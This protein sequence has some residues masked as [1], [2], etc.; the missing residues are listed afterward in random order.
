MRQTPRTLL[1]KLWD[2]HVVAQETDSPAVLYVDLHFINEV[3]SLLAFAGLRRR[4]F[5]V[6]RPDRTVAT[7]DH[8][9]S[10]DPLRLSAVGSAGADLVAHL[11]ENCRQ[12]TVT[13]YRPDSEHQGITHVIGP[14]LGLTQPGMTVASGDS[15]TCTHGAF[16]ALAI[17]TA[18]SGVEHLLATQCLLED[19][20][21]AFLVCVEGQ[22]RPGVSA[23]D[24]ILALIAQIGVD[25]GAGHALEFAGQAVRSMDMEGRLTLCNMAVEA[26]ARTGM[27]APD[28]VT[29]EYL[30]EREFAPRGPAWER[31]VRRWRELA[32]DE[33]ATYHRSVDIDS[34]SLEPMISYG[35]NPAMSIP[36]THVVPDPADLP[37]A[38]R[39][40]ALEA[41]LRYMNL[42]PGRPLLGHKVDV[43]FIG[44]C[45]NSRLSDLRQAAALLVGR[46]VA[47]GVRVLVVPG[48]QA[49]KRQAEAEGLARI[50]RQAGAEWRL[51]G[52]SMCIA[53]NGD[54]LEPGQY[55]VSTI[56]RSFEGRQGRGGRT[57]LASPLTAAAAAITGRVTD[58]RT[59]L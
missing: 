59:L 25:G 54:Q 40:T 47:Q 21:D 16:G 32:T 1:D 55:A 11:E 56:N 30:A 20:P 58:P 24:V 52:C 42:Q 53:M 9:I 19:K 29:F 2:D 5:A 12:F 13:Y 46:S 18:T 8:V 51:P 31:A 37:E 10:T 57:F 49:V 14:E 27:I 4:G 28:D 26:G 38:S 22:L 41:A 50:F 23:K 6:R 17:G 7:V 44:S 36:I 43:V 33:G 35:T 3:D 15:H 45:T 34:S 48:S 39:R